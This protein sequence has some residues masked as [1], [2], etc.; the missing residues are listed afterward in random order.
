MFHVRL[1]F[2]LLFILCVSISLNVVLYS[3]NSELKREVEALRERLKPLPPAENKSLIE[4]SPGVYR[5]PSPVLKG[6]LSVEEAIYRRRSRR[7]FSGEPLTAFEL[8]QILWAAQ[9]ITDPERGFR[10][11]PSAGATYPMEVYAVI[12]DNGVKGLK[13]GVYKYDPYTHSITLVLEGD[14]RELLAVQAYGQEWVAKAPVDIVLT[15]VYERTTRVYGERGVRYV[16]MEAGHIGQNIY[17]ICE[18]MGLGTVV[19]GAFNDEGVKK[20]LKLPE[21]EMPLYII[22]IGK[23]S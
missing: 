6:S 22:P 8:S 15:A 1:N 21:N 17:L 9:G 18:A 23:T 3:L 12:G 5:L 2:I 4:V 11:A 20:L 16:H 10:A 14:L 13:A 19:V 7:E